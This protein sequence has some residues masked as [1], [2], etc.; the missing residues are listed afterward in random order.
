MPAIGKSKAKVY[1]KENTTKKKVIMKLKMQE[2]CFKLFKKRVQFH[3][4]HTSVLLH[5]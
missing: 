4:E 5:M 3:Q 2:L 1:S